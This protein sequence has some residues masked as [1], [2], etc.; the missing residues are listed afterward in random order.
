[1]PNRYKDKGPDSEGIDKL[2]NSPKIPFE[3]SDKQILT[4]YLERLQTFA[5]IS[6]EVAKAIEKRDQDERK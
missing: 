1:M 5:A 3:E 6:T 2:Y 4:L